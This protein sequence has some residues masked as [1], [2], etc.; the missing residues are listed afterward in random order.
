MSMLRLSCLAIYFLILFHFCHPAASLL[1][2]QVHWLSS[3]SVLFPPVPLHFGKCQT[4]LLCFPHGETHQPHRLGNPRLSPQRTG[5]WCQRGREER[6]FMLPSLPLDPIHTNTHSLTHTCTSD[7]TQPCSMC[8]HSQASREKK[9]WKCGHTWCTLNG[10]AISQLW[11]WQ[12]Y[13]LKA[14][15]MTTYS[16]QSLLIIQSYVK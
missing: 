13:L 10:F 2:L 4:K 11:L 6:A 12:V 14:A 16:P 9:E 1:F 7:L 5:E 3:P 8:A 15:P